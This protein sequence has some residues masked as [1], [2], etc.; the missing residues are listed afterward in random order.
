MDEILTLIPGFWLPE[1]PNMAV[2][3]KLVEL[4][5]ENF[6]NRSI[7]SLIRNYWSSHIC[8]ATMTTD[9]TTTTNTAT[10]IDST[11]TDEPVITDPTLTDDTT[12]A[13]YSTTTDD[14]DTTLNT[15]STKTTTLEIYSTTQTNQ[16]IVT[17]YVPGGKCPAPQT[18]VLSTH[19]PLGT[20]F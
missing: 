20:L 9:S 7:G 5:G 12:T 8:T 6:I 15:Y 2:F 19:P 16:Y 10:T 18:T 11:T 13:D 14:D 4:T 3:D 1:L 17:V